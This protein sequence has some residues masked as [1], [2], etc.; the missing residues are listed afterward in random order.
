MRGFQT[1]RAKQNFGN[2]DPNVN[3]FDPAMAGRGNYNNADS[4]TAGSG[5]AAAKPGQK[6]QVNLTFV[7]AA[8]V[9]LTFEVFYFLNSFLRVLNPAYVPATNANYKYIPQD[10]Y[11][12]IQGVAAGTDGTVGFNS[13]GSLVIR[14]RGATGGPDPVATLGCGEIAYASFFAA[15]GIT[16]FSV[17][18]I[19]MTV[20]TDS[21][22]DNQVVYIKKSYSGGQV[23]NPISPRS[24]FQPNQFQDFIVDIAAAFDIGIDTGLRYIV[25]NGETV[26]FAL[27]INMWTNQTLIS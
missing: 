5:I 17:T 24:F 9:P 21:Q 26:K 3:N 1:F 8:A 2:Y 22:I 12:G 10:S 23:E 18:G 14:G 6:M 7:N 11:E 25:N 15:S 27:F 4:G 19:R 16:P 20:T 13:R